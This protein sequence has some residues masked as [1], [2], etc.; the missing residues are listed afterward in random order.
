MSKVIIILMMCAAAAVA[1]RAGKVLYYQAGV[2]D[3]QHAYIYQN[4]YPVLNGGAQLKQELPRWNFSKVF[5][6]A[7]QTVTLTFHPEPLDLAEQMPMKAPKVTI[8]EEWERFLILCVKDPKNKYMPIKL[9]AINASNNAF[10]P[11]DLYFINFTDV[12]VEGKLG[13]STLVLPP[14]KK[15]NVDGKG[16]TNGRDCVA[17]LNYLNAKTGE[18]K[19]FIRQSWGHTG[20]VRRVVF[21]FK[22]PN[23]R[24]S[25]YVT[26]IQDF[27]N[28]AERKTQSRS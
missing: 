8:P 26:S 12:R 25:Y 19:P 4:G 22:K 15:V 11:G 27:E 6:I 21:I 13:E 20:T 3:P 10:K 17:R 28:T 9:Y 2:D 1:Q 14:Y 5:E 7:P 16:T 23:G 24:L 18:S